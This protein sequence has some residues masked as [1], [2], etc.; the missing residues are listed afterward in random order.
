MLTTP[1]HIQLNLT[2][3]TLLESGSR[4]L[5]YVSYCGLTIC[6]L[7]PWHGQ[8]A[9][10]FAVECIVH[11]LLQYLYG[12]AVD[13]TF[14]LPEV[15]VRSGRSVINYNISFHVAYDPTLA[16]VVDNISWV[17][18]PMAECSPYLE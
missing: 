12:T 6:H 11:L 14:Y 17:T 15:L 9:R 1:F 16:L 7:P 2:E 3:T 5:S 10:H 8:T 4:V 13:V 18:V